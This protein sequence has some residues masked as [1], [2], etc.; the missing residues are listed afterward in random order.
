[1][2]TKEEIRA[3]RIAAGLTQAEAGRVCYM[4]ERGWQDIER[5]VR[6][7]KGSNRANWELFLL[8]TKTARKSAK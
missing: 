1:M 6:E 2:P 8:K 3:A 7:V 4:S 5:G